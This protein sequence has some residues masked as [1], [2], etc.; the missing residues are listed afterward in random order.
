MRC[1]A[2]PYTITMH[3]PTRIS[4]RAATRIAVSTPPPA[5]SP[6]HPFTRSPVHPFTR[7]HRPWIA[8]RKK[9]HGRLGLARG[10][11][12]GNGV[13]EEEE[14]PAHD[15]EADHRQDAVPSRARPADHVGE[16]ERTE[17]PREL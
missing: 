15:E 6:V 13:D 9:A 7:P 17:D 12:A 2:A 10:P 14:R 4:A 3:P 1:A 5:S 8:G 11:L 16:E